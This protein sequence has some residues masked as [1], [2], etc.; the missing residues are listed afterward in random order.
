LGKI[1]VVAKS[2][3]KSRR[4]IK[5]ESFFEISHGAAVEKLLDMPLGEVIFRPS[6]S[7]PGIYFGLI[8]IA[9]PSGDPTKEDWIKVVRFS[10]GPSARSGKTGSKTVFKILDAGADEFEEFDQMKVVFVDK[11][12]RFLSDIKAHPKFRPEHPDQVRNMLL[13][14]MRTGTQSAVAYSLVMDHRRECAGNALLLWAG[15]RYKVHDDI[16]EITHRGFKWWSRGPFPSVNSLLTWWKQG[17][18]R[19]RAQRMKEWQ[20]EQAKKSIVS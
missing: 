5:H 10:E 16:I 9:Q 12:M 15:D 20:D 13:A 6:T 17:G 3:V 14:K 4:I 18:Y 2:V 19:E 11:Y 7:Q 1:E 8:K